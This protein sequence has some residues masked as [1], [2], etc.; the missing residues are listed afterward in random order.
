[1]ASLSEEDRVLTQIETILPLLKRGIGVHHSGL[2]PIVKET[3]E[4]LFGESLIKI[5]FATETFAMGVNMPARSCI[6]TGL[7]KFDGRS[8]RNVTSGEYI[9]MSGRAG[10]RNRDDR[11]ICV[12]MIDDS[13]DAQ[14]LEQIF[15]GPADRL[16][17]TFRL[18]YN[19]ILNLM[20]A[21]SAAEPE[22]II[23]ASL[24]QFQ[25]D[26]EQP[27]HEQQIADLEKQLATL[28]VPHHDLITAYEQLRE[29][30]LSLG[31]QLVRIASLGV[32]SV[33]A[34]NK[35]RADH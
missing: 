8:F 10:R 24:H 5:L 33:G 34:N 18:S 12:T 32:E 25:H 26:T 23:K 22:A 16:V 1:M 17:S 20:R 15:C 19:M 27:R 35:Q 4:I 13:H 11:G 6:F 7:Q 21:E 30:G 3:V 28:N 2:L 9:Q 29:L 31:S 14:T